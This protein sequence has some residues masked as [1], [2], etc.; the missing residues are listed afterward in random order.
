[1]REASL[2]EVE[3]ESAADLRRQSL[4]TE[5][6]VYLLIFILHEPC[7]LHILTYLVIYNIDGPCVL[8]TS[9]ITK[10]TQYRDHSRSSKVLKSFS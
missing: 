4:L 6:Y 2:R 5:V 1:M 10:E 3:E 7:Y 9:F 8:T